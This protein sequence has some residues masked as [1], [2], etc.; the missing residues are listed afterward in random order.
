LNELGLI[1]SSNDLDTLGKLLRDV[2]ETT[3]HCLGHLYGV[4]VAFL[5]NRQLHRFA[6]VESGDDL[7]LLVATGHLTDVRYPDDPSLLGQKD[8]IHDVLEIH[9]FVVGA[10]QIASFLL[11]ETAAGLIHV[12]FQER[13]VHSLDTQAQERQLAFIDP[14]LDLL[15]VP[16]VDFDGGHTLGRFQVLLQHLLGHIAQLVE[17]AGPLH[18]EAQN[19]VVRGIETQYHGFGHVP[20][21]PHDIELLPHV[22]RGEVH[23]AAPFELQGHL[24]QAGARHRG[25]SLD[26]GDDTY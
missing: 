19:R 22:E 6:A 17:V 8:G 21:E 20:W 5:V 11:V 2:L 7:T 14:D 9:E 10:H 25:Q 18:V 1:D 13:L 23:V 4:G 24:R 3:L 26:P 16:A 12:V 15:F